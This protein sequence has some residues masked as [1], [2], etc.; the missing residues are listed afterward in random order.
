MNFDKYKNNGLTGLSNLGNTCFINSAIQCLSHSYELND[1]LN[2]EEYKKYM[3]KKVDTILL[4]EYDELRK[5]MW[6]ENCRISP[7]KFV[8]IIRKIAKIKRKDLFTGWAQNDLPEFLYFL[9]ECFHEGTCRE[10]EMEIKGKIENNEDELAKTCYEM[11]KRMYTKEYSDILKIFYG[12]SVT[13]CETIVKNNK[14]E[15]N[16][17]AEPFLMI[18][19]PI[20]NKEIITLKDCLDDYTKKE[21]IEIDE[22]NKKIKKTLYWSFPNIMIISLKRFNDNLKKNNV[23]VNY[24][25]DNLDMSEYVCGYNRNSYKYELFGICNHTGNVNGGHYFS[26][27]KNANGKWYK[28]NDLEVKE[29]NNKDIVTNMG[30]CLFYRKKK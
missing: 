23:L 9:F 30:Y 16:N 5:L 1:Y 3:N 6:S 29:I 20:V 26:Y 14:T 10:V 4:K 24:P 11:M 22:N 15:E 12:I 18:D 28:M 7:E 8:D 17:I 25:I 13:N 21:E 27:I 19:L 2:S